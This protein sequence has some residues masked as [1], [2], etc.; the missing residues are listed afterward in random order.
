MATKICNKCG[1]E[2]DRRSTLRSCPICHTKYDEGYCSICGAYC[3]G[4]DYVKHAYCRECYNEVFGAPTRARQYKQAAAENID[5]YRSWIDRIANVP[6][7]Y[8][9]LTEEQWLDACKHFRG[10]AIC[11]DMFISARAFFVPFS[12]GGRYCDWNIIPMCEECSVRWQTVT[13]VPNRL[14][15]FSNYLQLKNGKQILKNIQD[16]LE[17]RLDAAQQR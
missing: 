5:S 6:N 10:C 17:V 14:T 7:N 13:M 11:G 3:T 4:N 8:P 12:E 16:Y 1:W 2:I 9:T 15:P